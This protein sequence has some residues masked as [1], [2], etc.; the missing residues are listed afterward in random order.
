MFRIRSV[1]LALAALLL[2][3]S[4]V[5]AASNVWAHGYPKAKGTVIKIKGTATPDTGFT[6]GANGTA[7]VWPAGEKG[8]VVTT[9]PITVDPKTGQWSAD[10][11]GLKVD[12][13]YEFVV[14]A[15]QTMGTTTQTIATPPK[16]RRFDGDD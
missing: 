9:F 2:I 10:L 11:S 7:I 8:G 15:T 14:Q 3:G 4:S 16:S 1:A 5:S 12:T 6:L 13:N